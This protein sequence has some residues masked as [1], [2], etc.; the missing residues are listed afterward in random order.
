MAAPI[1]PKGGMSAKSN[2]TAVA[3][4]DI[5]SNRSGIERAGIAQPYLG[6]IRSTEANV[7]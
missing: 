4:D 2:S 7:G 6:R 5:A 3:K 1:I